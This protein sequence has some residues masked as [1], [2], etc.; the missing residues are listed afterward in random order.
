MRRAKPSHE[1]R[2]IDAA[3]VV[4]ARYGY[5]QGSIARIVAQAGVSRATFYQHFE[6]KEACFL[7]AYRAVTERIQQ[8][9]RKVGSEERGGADPTGLRDVLARLLANA[10]REPAAARVVL[11]EAL[12]AGPAVRAEHEGFLGK[13]EGAIDSYLDERAAERGMRLEIPARSLLGGVV[14]VV[15]SRVFRGETGRLGGLLDDLDAW[16]CA[17]LAPG[18]ERRNRFT[19][20]A[21]NPNLG[22][23]VAPE[24]SPLDRPPL[25]RSA[26]NSAAVVASDQR[27]RLLAAI[28]VVVSRK[29]YEETTVADVVATAGVAREAF[30][31]QFR[32]KEDVFLAAQAHAFQTSLSMAA[33]QF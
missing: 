13:L 26:T 28:A 33:E 9:V 19:W 17:Y 12:A 18:R 11:L 32:S 27:Q 21:L 8:D 3:I 5:R 2:L 14:N 31:E 24:P 7:A 6:D 4:I 20:A 30:Y 29:G 22:P 23:P 25:R 16:L 1:E 15:A 10:D